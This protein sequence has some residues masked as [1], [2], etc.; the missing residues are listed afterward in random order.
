MS[1][2]RKKI[3]KRLAIL[4]LFISVF[5]IGLIFRLGWLQII[6]GQELQK[7]ALLQWTKEI[8]V[9]PKRGTIFDRHGKELAISASADTIVAYPPE[10]KDAEATAKALSEILDLDEEHIL[11]LITKKKSSV[12]IK[13]KVEDEQSKKIRELGLAGIGFTQE[14]KRYYPDRNLA[15]HILGFVGVDSQGLAGI[16]YHYD[17]Y[18]KGYP[19]RIVSETDAMSRELPFGAQ[20]FIPPKDGFN[21]TLT[22]DKVIQHFTVKE[23]EKAVN[24]HKAKR[25]TALV[26]NPRT[27]EILALANK[28]DFDP[29]EYINYPSDAWKNSAISDTYEP[30]STF[31]IITAATAL[32]EKIVS[33]DTRYFDSGSI[34]VSGVRIKCWR[35]GG[36][37]SQTFTQVVQ[38]S[39]NPGFVDVAMKLGKDKFV[40]Y[41]EAFG[42]GRTLGL[43]FPGEGKGIFNPSK[44]GPV[45]LATI[46]F[47]QGISVTPLQLLTATCAV[48]NDGKLMKPYL[49]R[50]IMNNDG[51]IIHEFEP[52]LLR[53]VVSKNTSEEMRN[54]LEGVVTN[55]TGGNAKIEGYKVAGKTGTSEKYVD[56]KYI[57]SFIGFA[58]ADNPEVA[59]LVTLDEPQGI[60]YG[61]QTAGPAFKQIMEE[62]LKYLGIKPNKEETESGLLK[63][64]DVTNL[65]VQEACST[66]IKSE[67]EYIIKGAGLIVGEQNP[68][69]GTLISPDDKVELILIEGK[70]DKSPT[71]IPDL[72]GKTIKESQEILEIIGLKAQIIGSGFATRQD[73]APGTNVDLG[74]TVKIFF[75]QR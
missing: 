66:L 54:I 31:K 30:G 48:A 39:C 52:K 37:G 14:S 75:E 18:V 8:P 46:S 42:F 53:Q 74:T 47:G 49:V 60:Y 28:P 35:H 61:G 59:I 67:L 25:G 20:H 33:P 29:N 41:I 9:E 34:V 16:E 50:N 23:L 70:T 4:L 62:T 2:T 15:S 72:T 56:G 43:D 57:S 64:P 12:Y 24:L 27:G 63:V 71:Q 32:E 69:A 13:R 7:K 22:I 36:H 21:L 68:G 40:K 58:P 44:I 73:P 65:Y 38:N 1:V 55:G 51:D 10:I 6:K 19:G 3:K 26:M 17:K 11:E 5:Y 45:E